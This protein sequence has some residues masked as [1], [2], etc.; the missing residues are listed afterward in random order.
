[1][2]EK[3][4]SQNRS[5]KGVEIPGLHQRSPSVNVGKEWCL[6]WPGVKGAGLGARPEFGPTEQGRAQEAYGSNLTICQIVATAIQ[7]AGPR[8]AFIDFSNKITC[9]KAHVFLTV[10]DKKAYYRMSDLSLCLG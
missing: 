2:F 5:R 9:S 8:P 6:L 4:R 1:M 10:N 7:S 3:E